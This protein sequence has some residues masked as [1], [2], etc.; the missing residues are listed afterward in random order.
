MAFKF[1][2]IIYVLN[3]KTLRLTVDLSTDGLDTSPAR[4]SL[5]NGHSHERNNSAKISPVRDDPRGD[6]PRHLVT[7]E[8]FGDFL[9][10]PES[11]ANQTVQ[12]IRLKAKRIL[13]TQTSPSTKPDKSVPKAVVESWLTGR[14]TTSVYEGYS[15]Q[16]EEEEDEDDESDEE[17]EP[18]VDDI[19]IPAVPIL[20]KPKPKPQTLTDGKTFI[21]DFQPHKIVVLYI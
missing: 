20:H 2:S 11:S 7:Y 17:E 15:A 21:S 1:V 18:S 10:E 6:D 13:P 3:Y 9:D 14:S 12:T 16:N 4:I 8:D 19:V 5:T